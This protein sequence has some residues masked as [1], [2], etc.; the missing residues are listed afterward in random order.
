MR[1]DALLGLR[2][3]LQEHPSL[4]LPNLGKI[5][6]HV[7]NAVVD[8]EASVRRAL[9]MFLKFLFT[10]TKKD[11]LQPFFSVLVAHLTCGL[12]HINDK[13]Q[14]DSLTVFDLVLTHYSHLLVPHA[15]DL[16]PLFASL[17][18]RHETPSA[19]K[20]KTTQQSLDPALSSN[21]ST[22]LSKQS[23]RLEI[24]SQLCRFLQ[25]ILEHLEMSGVQ[26]TAEAP[27]IDIANRRVHG[28]PSYLTFT[29]LSS[30]IPH[31]AIVQTHGIQIPPDAFL[32]SPE[33]AA[34]TSPFLGASYGN[35]FPQHAKLLEFIQILISLLLECWLE[36]S[37]SQLHAHG[38]IKHETLSLMEAI[39]NLLCLVMKLAYQVDEAGNMSDNSRLMQI[40]GEKL[41][42]DF[43]K[44]FLPYFPF[45]RVGSASVQKVAMNC[46][47]AHTMLLLLQSKSLIKQSSIGARMLSSICDYFATL[48]SSSRAI[49]ASSQLLMPYVKSLVEVLPLLGASFCNYAVSEE[50]K[51]G[52]FSGIHS[53]YYACHPQ[54]AAKRALL[55]CFSEIQTKTLAKTQ[56]MSNR[57][58]IL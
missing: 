50:K 37:P 12:T 47:I 39:L 11:H 29:D 26:S 5:V 34:S 20:K 1:H 27:V 46:S 16:L 8:V 54:S 3:L 52:L 49:A 19:A 10:H 57:F 25:V 55:Q 58:V 30:P 51:E 45:G 42:T 31:V 35:I 14:L 43:Q 23:S 56:S 40:L 44:H 38:S 6:E 28:G 36:C 17:V 32:S 18:L 7:F 24:F 9:C 22:M 48:E 21:P 2:D 15:Q 4:L 33:V 41:G 53:L 13:I